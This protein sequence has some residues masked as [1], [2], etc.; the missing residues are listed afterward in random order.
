[1]GELRPAGLGQADLEVSTARPVEPRDFPALARFIEQVN[2]RPAARDLH[3]YET[4]A[5]ALTR[6]MGEFHA[7][8]RL[9]GLVEE[10]AGG[11]V[12]AVLFDVDPDKGGAWAWGPAV[13]PGGQADLLLD[14]GLELLPAKIARVSFFLAAENLDFQAILA[15][16]GAQFRPPTHIYRAVPSDR[17]ATRPG[18]IRLARP[19]DRAA[20]DRLHEAHF[21]ASYRSADEMLADD[22][23]RSRLL[24]A[25]A[26][27]LFAGYLAATVQ[28]DGTGYVDFL[29]T[30]PAFRRQGIATD[31]LSAGLAW[32]FGERQVP[33]ACLTVSDDK[34]GA[35]RLYERAGFRLHLSG[36]PADLLR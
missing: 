6:Q 34:A 13:A 31:L 23:A 32:L 11:P 7:A 18:G 14:R 9:I 10:R 4:P 17:P 35:R 2:D 21:P 5:D 24:V 26:G 25:E 27:G 28:E 22:P 12:G 15:A 8:G 3:T 36:I 20:L 33:S 16:R 29:A 19:E 30:D 1:M